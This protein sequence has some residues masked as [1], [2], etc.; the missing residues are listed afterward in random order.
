MYAHIHIYSK[1]PFNAASVLRGII[2]IPLKRA[3]YWY[4]LY[5]CANET[6]M[7]QPK[8]VHYIG[9]MYTMNLFQRSFVS[10]SRIK[11]SNVFSDIAITVWTHLSSLCCLTLFR[12][13]LEHIPRVKRGLTVYLCIYI[14][15]VCKNGTERSAT[16]N[17]N[18][19]T[20]LAMSQNINEIIFIFFYYE[21][22][23][24]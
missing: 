15:L 16:T 23:I 2:R 6:A 5:M 11:I 22:F 10:L 21:V 14:V 12:L 13:A 3:L 20:A 9:K 17:L 18:K 24:P 1:T 19:V 8:A 4:L 7:H